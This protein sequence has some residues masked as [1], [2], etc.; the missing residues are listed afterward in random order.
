MRVQARV[1]H[2][3]WQPDCTSQLCFSGTAPGMF[4][5]WGVT[6]SRAAVA[7][8]LSLEDAGEAKHK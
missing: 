4:S 2:A 8:T 3:V 5:E 7:E 1:T 6:V